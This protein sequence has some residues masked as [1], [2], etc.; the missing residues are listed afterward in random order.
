MPHMIVRH[1]LLKEN[2][3]SITIRIL[4]EIT[5]N[6]HTM[7]LK[8]Y[9][10]LADDDADDC[11]LF[12]DALREVC[13]ETMLTTASDGIELMDYLDENVPPS[14]DVIFL[15]LNMPRKNGF[16][17][18]AE[19]KAVHKLKNIPIIIFSTSSDKE[20]VDKVYSQ[21]ADFYLRKP[22]SFPMLKSAIARV[23]SINWQS[24]SAQPSRE[25]F[26][27]TF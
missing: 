17:C 25:N 2:Y 19:L 24:H 10:F 16:E 21:G 27:L 6:L 14:P 12:E 20:Y 11:V 3:T 4:P 8:K 1:L 26:M 7:N 18:L 9:I 5:C 15:D 22:E 23:L 13:S